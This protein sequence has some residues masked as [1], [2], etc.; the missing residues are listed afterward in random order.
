[1]RPPFVFINETSSP[2]TVEIRADLLWGH[3][4]ELRAWYKEVV[5]ALMQP[6]RTDAPRIILTE[7][8]EKEVVGWFL[9]RKDSLHL[10][11]LKKKMDAFY[12]AYCL[13]L[14][15]RSRAS[16]EQ[17]EQDKRQ[18]F[19]T[20]A[21]LCEAY[22][23]EPS[24][25]KGNQLFITKLTVLAFLV[26]L[27]LASD[28]NQRF[29][30]ITGYRA[31]TQAFNFPSILSIHIAVPLLR[32]E[33]VEAMKQAFQ[34]LM[35]EVFHPPEVVE[36][37]SSLQEIEQA[38]IARERYFARSVTGFLFAGLCRKQY[39]ALL[40][41]YMEL[42]REAWKGEQANLEALDSQLELAKYMVTQASG[43]RQ[44]ECLVFTKQ[45]LQEAVYRYLRHASEYH[46]VLPDETR[47]QLLA[48]VELCAMDKASLHARDLVRAA[49][50]VRGD[51]QEYLCGTYSVNKESVALLSVAFLKAFDIAWEE[52]SF[53]EGNAAYYDKARRAFFD[54]FSDNGYFLDPDSTI[55]YRSLDRT[56]ILK[57]LQAGL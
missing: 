4:F 45:L 46:L 11:A 47:I 54:A 52:P 44:I 41:L 23:L 30:E 9:N 13:F 15:S 50:G 6:H 37:F 35:K 8:I 55:G 1:M 57:R 24:L 26:N 22:S 51:F 53:A 7:N 40:T 16:D 43:M 56:E 29:R 28:E 49:R 36:N 14:N 17:R 20:L 48:L 34:A 42:I 18:C 32:E 39:K 38:V 21:A 31:E 33:R 19:K 5:V 2:P 10:Q 27:Y 25:E 3:R 12:D